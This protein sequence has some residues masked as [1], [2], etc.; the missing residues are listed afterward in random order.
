M[1]H[2]IEISNPIAELLKQLPNDPGV[3]LMHDKKGDILYVG[4]AKNLHHRVRSY[5]HNQERLTPKTQ[6]LVAHIADL[7][8]FVTSSEQEALLLELHLIKRHQPYYNVRLRDDKTYPYL[9]IDVNEDWPT[10]HITRRLEKNGSHYFGPFTSA[11]SLR[12]TLRVLKKTFPLRSCT[13]VIRG[14][15]RRPCLEYHIKRCP[16]PCIGAISREE[17]ASIVKQVILFL[18]GKNELVIRE[19]KEQMKKAA[20]SLDFERAATTRDQ[21]QAINK[22][23]AEQRIATRVKEEQ[24]VIAFV[25]DDDHAYVQVFFIRSGNLLGRESFVLQGT[26]SEEAS[27]IMTSFVLQF[28]AVAPGIPPRLTLQHAIRDRALIENWL[29]DKRG[30]KVRVQVPR[31]GNKKYLVDIAAKNARQSREQLRIKQLSSSSALA[32]ALAEIKETLNLSNLPSR[33]ECYDISNIQG[34]AAVGSMVVFEDGRS[35]PSHY[36]RF[37]IKSVSGADDYAMLQEVI[38][39]R[40]KRSGGMNAE[41]NTWARLPD[42]ILID[43]GRGQLNSV[44]TAMSE[45]GVISVPV[46]ALAKENEEIFVPQKTDPIIL[47][48]SSPGLQM[49]ERLR[50][51]AHRFALGYHQKVHNKQAFSSVLD[52]VPGIG[53]RRRRALLKHFG[54][55][56]AIREAPSEELAAVNGMTHQVAR[57]LKE[58]I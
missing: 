22:V 36:R 13:R 37:K 35:K 27:Q 44:V 43:G 58:Y 2:N 42:L 53:P 6:Q 38:K 50:D 57:K 33:M 21:L 19:L 47:S 1:S 15:D 5:F 55:I 34:S 46:A 12:R 24:D 40:F 45:L 51:E 18:E 25:N 30:G 3:Y 39:R 9:R 17:Y 49:L 23:I 26:H 16:A 32:A 11:V 7:E 31:R 28:Y 10:M 29:S 54:S 4:K 52:S 14:T 48:R 41:A 8:Y 20:D 56:A